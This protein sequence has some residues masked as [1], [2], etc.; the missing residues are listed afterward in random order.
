MIERSGFE[1][2]KARV[3]DVNKGFGDDEIKETKDT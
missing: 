1:K 3:P 2:K